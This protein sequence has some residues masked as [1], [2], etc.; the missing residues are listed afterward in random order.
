MA[1]AACGTFHPPGTSLGA[2][3]SRGAGARTASDSRTSNPSPANVPPTSASPAPS[4]SPA[5][6]SGPC[7]V[8]IANI[9]EADGWFITYP[10]GQRQD[11]PSSV[12][13][14][15]GGTPGQV[16][17][18]P[19]LTY[20]RT[21][22]RWVPMPYNWLSPDGTVYAYGFGTVQSVS[23]LTGQVRDVASGGGWYPLTTVNDGVY[24]ART[25]APGA[26]FIPFGG[27]PRQVIDHGSWLQFLD[28]SMWGADS[29]GNFIRHEMTSG[30]ETTWA[31]VTP[32]AWIVGFDQSGHPLVNNGGAL[33][34]VQG[35]GSVTTLWPGTN[36]LGVG[37][38]AV[39]DS[40]GVWFE[41]GS[42]LVGAPGHGLYLWTPAAG[43]QLIATPEAN[44]AGGCG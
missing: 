15:P 4:S 10:G 21:A 33:L 34:L 40:L 31:K 6:A 43:A 14:L 11:D 22:R 20:D 9:S 3:S 26:W 44:L 32:S 41:V 38:R 27:Q 24:A 30:T 5:S 28:G 23:V 18:N 2:D 16:G 13:A 42:G 7:R 36:D 12:V 39:A 37:G 1:L 19:G 29:S 25:G 8:P 35:V 17:Q